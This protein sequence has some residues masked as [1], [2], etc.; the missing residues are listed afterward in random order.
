MRA[1]A[2][3]IGSVWRID[4]SDRALRPVADYGGPQR[5]RAVNLTS[6]LVSILRKHPARSNAGTP[7]YS[8]D[9]AANPRFD[10]PL[11]RLIP[12]RSVL[13]QPFRVNGEIAGIFA[14][15]WTRSRHRFTDVELRLVEAVT[16]QA[17]IAIENAELVGELQQFTEQLSV[18][19]AIARRD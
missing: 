16:Q 17:G 7:V 9:S 12:H 3:D 18:G 19:C 11:L 14:F 4:P 1:L 5:L 15:I 2:A 8:S 6:S 10:N 13:I